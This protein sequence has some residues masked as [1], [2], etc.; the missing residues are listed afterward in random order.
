MQENWKPYPLDPR[1]LVSD[2]GRVK[3]QKGQIL[4]GSLNAKNGYLKIG[5]Y[6]HGKAIYKFIHRM[7]L[8]TFNPIEDS[9]NFV[10]N[11]IDGDKTNNTLENLEWTTQQENIIH[12]R[13]KLKISYKT[14]AAHAARR[15]KVKMIDVITQEE[16][17]FNSIQECANFLNV[18]YQS[19]QYYLKHTEKIFGTKKFERI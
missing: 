6:D 14:E 7:V 1:Y 2:K 8:E 13:D 16:N 17:I 12:A 11:H 3:G 19:V 4:K 15:S 9:E 5:L 10:V 18:K